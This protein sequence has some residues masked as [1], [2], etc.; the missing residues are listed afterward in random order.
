MRRMGASGADDVDRLRA[1]I[2]AHERFV[3][4]EGRRSA[5]D[6]LVE[7]EELRDLLEPLLAHARPPPP[8]TDTERVL[9]DFRLLG[10]LGRG[11][12][13][14]V[15]DAEQISLGRRVAVKV[16]PGRLALDPGRRA[17]FERESRLA[18]SLDHPGIA[19]VISADSDGEVVWFAM[20]R[21]DGA[22]LDQVLLRTAVTQS[23]SMTGRRLESVVGDVARE[24]GVGGSRIEAATD[25]SGST[26]WRSGYVDTVVRIGAQIADAL[27]H[28]H[29]QGVI[30]RD[31]K[32][33][34][35]LL[36]RDGSA[37]LTDF[38]LARELQAPSVT[39]T[40]DFLGTPSYSAPEQLAGERA[41]VDHRTDVF[42]LGVTL[43]EL[44]THKKPFEASSSD[45]VRTRILT[46]EPPRPR[47]L[48]RKIPPD[49]S[50]VLLKALEKDP[51]RRYQS[52]AAMAAD[53]RAVAQGRPVKAQVVRLHRRGWRW[54][55]RN[56]WAATAL[57]SMLGVVL[58]LLTIRAQLV[59]AN[60]EQA[61][62]TIRAGVALA[63]T[64]DFRGALAV[65]MPLERQFPGPATQ[66]ALDELF[67][68]HP[69]IASY[70]LIGKSNERL[71]AA[72]FSADGTW[73]T[74]RH[75]LA[76][77]PGQSWQRL[78]RVPL[79][80]SSAPQS[81]WRCEWESAPTTHYRGFIA[82][83]PIV[84]LKDD[85]TVAVGG[86]DRKTSEIEFE[87]RV[88]GLIQS[89]RD[90]HFG[91][92]FEKH[93]E[94]RDAE[95][96]L[97][98]EWPIA[99]DADRS[100]IRILDD[101]LV[102]GWQSLDSRWAVG[103]TAP[104]SEPI[105]V[106]VGVGVINL[107][108][109]DPTRMMVSTD[110]WITALRS[111]NGELVP[112]GRGASLFSGGLNRAP[113]RN[114][115]GELKEDG[116]RLSALSE[117]PLWRSA[118][119]CSRLYTAEASG[120]HEPYIVAVED[121]VLRVWGTPGPRRLDPERSRLEIA[122][123]E[124]AT[125]KVWCAG[126]DTLA[127]WSLDAKGVGARED[128]ETPLEI[129]EVLADGKAPSFS[130]MAFDP[131][132]AVL[133]CARS[134]VQ[135]PTGGWVFVLPAG[136]FGRAK[137]YPCR[138]EPGWIELS[139]DRSQLAVAE[140]DGGVELWTYDSKLGVLTDRVALPARPIKALR[141]S[142]VRYLGSRFLLGTEASHI[143]KGGLLRWDLDAPGAPPV[144]VALAEVRGGLRCLTVSSAGKI[145]ATGGD[146][147]FVRV[148]RVAR[149][150]GAPELESIWRADHGAAVFAV[151]FAERDGAL[152][153]ASGDRQGGV[154]LW[155]AETGAERG[156]LR[157]STE[158]GGEMILS[159]D[160][161]EDGRYLAA[162]GSSGRVLLWDLDRPRRCLEGNRDC[163]ERLLRLQAEV[164]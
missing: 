26:V 14:V 92:S 10:E 124:P 9:G 156:H 22:P 36:R 60:A 37:V 42:A 31:V 118:S 122:R 149:K 97:I 139:S 127:T 20:E 120:T 45:E 150:D 105:D 152:I 93:V 32:P 88:Q 99:R 24:H 158:G 58:L 125:R 71:V 75:E 16:L 68:R 142:C 134:D 50:S 95:G 13:G 119:L 59:H 7:H 79:P 108:P 29:Q 116:P 94:L 41:S 113:L 135:L 155:D 74:T 3:L 67:R 6:F 63:R 27:Q 133:A 70:P 89:S 48:N 117:L 109:D 39:L 52:A 91:V 98:H 77:T 140:R 66:A 28:A 15:Y 114:E 84:W 107:D 73:L 111:I 23:A 21:I 123:F 153:L 61:E 43:Y 136:D 129:R 141:L 18:A 154:R 164:R 157:D 110:G 163:A 1:A 54:C 69:C 151:A 87:D 106:G 121:R 131:G 53:L 162:C 130:G 4:E 148:M 17:R 145:V 35:V 132:R 126:F 8:E 161:S 83:P 138:S 11:G 144:P 47:R 72:L 46:V 86:P 12:M 62:S 30:H 100:G 65:L 85:R 101:V 25:K 160:F 76:D 103:S 102:R 64:Q 2:E 96:R 104:G 49:L 147:R 128:V 44:L 34:N 40:G 33:G 78:W 112:D 55:R 90:G 80:N 115:A 143:E 5:S 146:D 56:R 57:A 159:L 38:G 137:A 19:K 82:G 81:A 51:N